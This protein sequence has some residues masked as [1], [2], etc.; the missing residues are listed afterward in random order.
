[1]PPPL[2]T[3]GVITLFFVA[4]LLLPKGGGGTGGNGSGIGGASSGAAPKA[5]HVYVAEKRAFVVDK[6]AA[7]AVAEGRDSVRLVSYNILG[8]GAKLAL[9][10]KH[11]YCPRELRVWGDE[12][13][14]GGKGRCTRLVEEIAG[15]QPDLLCVQEL[16]I[17]MMADLSPR[18]ATKA[19]GLQQVVHVGN[20]STTNPEHEHTKQFPRG[21]IHKDFIGT[22]I[23][24]NPD[25]GR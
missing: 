19:I 9:S 24:V 14:A 20:A 1:M 7:E 8:D 21:P 5:G 17:R 22:A 12:G 10:E 25:K 4:A 13:A 23:F 11:G 18:L 3:I 15:Y 6:S 16:S 2:T